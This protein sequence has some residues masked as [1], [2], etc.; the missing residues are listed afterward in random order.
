MSQPKE[1]GCTEIQAWLAKTM[2]RKWGLI[3]VLEVEHSGE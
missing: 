1:E 3:T 2:K